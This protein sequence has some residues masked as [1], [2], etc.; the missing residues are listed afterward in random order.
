MGPAGF[1]PRDGTGCGSGFADGGPLD[2][3]AAGIALAGFADEACAAAG[4]LDDDRLVGVLRA[5]RRL[6]SWAQARE[7]AMIAELARRRPADRTPPAP[8]G[9]FPAELSEFVPD[10]VAMALTLTQRAAETQVGLALDLAGRPAI[11][12]ALETGR[13]DLPRARILLDALGP[14]A[15]AHAAAVQAAIV[16]A[17]PGLTTG[18]LRAEVNQ[19]IL[20][21][22]PEAMRRR[23]QEAEQGARVECYTNPDGTATLTGR[24][25]PPAEVLAADKRLCQVAAW[26]KKQ[27]R[28]AWKQ[29]DPAGEL[30]RPEHGTDLLRARAYL[31]L[32]L[33]QPLDTPPAGFLP[34]AD[35]P[36]AQTTARPGQHR[37]PGRHGQ[38]GRHRQPG[39]HGAARTAPPARTARARPRAA[40]RPRASSC[41]AGRTC[42]PGCAAPTRSPTRSPGPTAATRS[43]GCRR[44]PARSTSP[45][46]WPP[47]SACPTGPASPPAT[48]RCPATSPAPWPP[49]PSRTRRP[50][51]A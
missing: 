25:L 21:L 10:E 6:T 43:P 4:A 26:W 30:A 15:A 2:V 16:P 51:G 31:A 11:A 36:P 22:D 9:Q 47:C 1:V 32:L 48:A 12:A 14:L 28:A 23:R 37:Q 29:A 35:L 24:W 7:L 33:G 42:P 19:A 45:C 27:I 5:W 39:P 13:I 38:P 44:W 34:P 3:L 17:A 46:R 18:E 20:A 50:A 40:A 49:P 8:P 41:P